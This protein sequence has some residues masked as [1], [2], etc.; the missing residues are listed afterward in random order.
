MGPGFTERLQFHNDAPGLEAARKQ[1]DGGT[2]PLTKHYSSTPLAFLKSEELYQSD[3]FAAMSR[4]SKGFL[5]QTTVPSFE[6][7]IVSHATA[8]SP[9]HDSMAH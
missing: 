7:A 1:L 6:F 4:G 2:G 8:Q 3:E 9:T 5:L